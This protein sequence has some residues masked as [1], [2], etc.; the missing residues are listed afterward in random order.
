MTQKE[1]TETVEETLKH[2]RFG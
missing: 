2:S 1:K